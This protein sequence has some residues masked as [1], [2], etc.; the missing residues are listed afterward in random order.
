MPGAPGEWGRLSRGSWPRPHPQGP[1]SR[2]NH[3]RH[4]PR[5]Q[6]ARCRESSDRACPGNEGG[7]RP[8]CHAGRVYRGCGPE[9]ASSPS[10]ADA[11]L[12]PHDP[13]PGRRPWGT[14]RVVGLGPLRVLVTVSFSSVSPLAHALSFHKR[15][16][17]GMPK[18]TRT[19]QVTGSGLKATVVRLRACPLTHLQRTVSVTTLQTPE[20]LQRL[21]WFYACH[22]IRG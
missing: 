2:Q 19:P 12:R 22:G 11:V 3:L 1:R 17:G 7:G 15:V 14:G 21:L 9:F 16:V 18:V 6:A 5:G 8:R 20:G 13:L 10:K 4:T